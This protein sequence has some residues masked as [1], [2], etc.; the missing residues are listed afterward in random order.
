MSHRNALMIHPALSFTR[1]QSAINRD[2]I[3]RYIDDLEN[4]VKE[5]ENEH[6]LYAEFA[7]ATLEKIKFVYSRSLRCQPL[8]LK[9]Y[10]AD[11]DL[12]QI[13]HSTTALLNTTVIKDDNTVN[14]EFTLACDKYAIMI[15]KIQ[16]KKNMAIF[17]GVISTLLLG[18]CVAGMALMSIF[19]S[20]PAALGCMVAILYL[21]H[22]MIGSFNQ[23]YKSHGLLKAMQP[24]LTSVRPATLEMGQNHH[25]EI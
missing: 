22:E 20:V 11:E 5:K 4:L 12:L 13:I 6:A 10:L 16:S 3:Q 23:A 15:D 14:P 7:Q 2:D 25:A 21:G 1:T 9:K 17:A 8:L 24:L 19:V 18:V